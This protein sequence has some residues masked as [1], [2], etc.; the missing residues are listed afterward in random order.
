MAPSSF[1]LMRCDRCGF[2]DDSYHPDLSQF[3]MVEETKRVIEF[4]KRHFR[5][6]GWVTSWGYDLC[7]N[8][9]KEM[10]NAASRG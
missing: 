8:C 4:V 7:P 10:Q 6:Q 3:D 2:I 5:E 1:S 9:V